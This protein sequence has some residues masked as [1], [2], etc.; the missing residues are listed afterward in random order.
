MRRLQ[1]SA[2]GDPASVITLETVQTPRLATDELLVKME[3]AAINPVDFMLV[4]GMYA[5]KPSF[6][7]NLGTE[8]VGRVVDTGESARSLQ[9]KRVIFLPTSEQGAWADE[10]VVHQRNVVVVGDEGDPLQ[11]AMLAINPATAY[12]VLQQYAHLMP[13]DW[14]GQTGANSAMGQ[15]II[16]LARLAGLNTVNVVRKQAAA[17]H[18]LSLG[19]NK[20]VLEGEGLSTQIADALGGRKLSLVLD[21]VGGAPIAELVPFLKVGGSAVGYALL[22]GEPP[23]FSPSYLY[24]NLSFHGFWLMN[25]LRTAT[26]DQLQETYQVLADLTARNVISAKVDATY[27]LD[28]YQEALA[29]AHQSGRTGK[30]LF[31]F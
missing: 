18:V 29:H 24:Q 4:A 10:V 9:D 11:L 28:G 30:V 15:Y 1:L 2:T 20:A 3:A 23:A 31:R 13:D 22:S 12:L 8:G 17:D 7:F 19:G 21:A 26:R 6:P 27:P 16:Q 14:I 25:W 5:V